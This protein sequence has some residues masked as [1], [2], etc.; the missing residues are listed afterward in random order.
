MGI[1]WPQG[2]NGD[3]RA[4]R[5]RGHDLKFPRIGPDGEIPPT[6]K[7]AAARRNLDPRINRHGAHF[8]TQD[9]IEV[10]ADDLLLILDQPRDAHQDV[11]NDPGIRR[12]HIAI[13]TE[14]ARNAR[15]G[16]QVTCLRQIERQQ[17]HGLVV[18][19]FDRRAAMAEQDHRTEGRIDSNADDQLAGM[20]PQDH[21]LDGHAIDACIGPGDAGP[22][23]NAVSRLLHRF[24]RS[25]AKPHP[26]DIGLVDDVA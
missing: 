18:D 11:R 21:G 7:V 14:Q 26:V 6:L 5:Q 13:P 3:P 4:V 23:E 24:R 9:R 15:A 20:G 19:H 12:R 10:D 22:G 17:R 1:G 8:V 25:Q 16:D 2:P